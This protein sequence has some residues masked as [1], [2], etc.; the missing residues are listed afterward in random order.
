[1]RHMVR[2]FRHPAT[3]GGGSHLSGERFRVGFGGI[4][5]V[6]INLYI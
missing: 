5:D 2:V 1:M 4:I 3:P 6:F